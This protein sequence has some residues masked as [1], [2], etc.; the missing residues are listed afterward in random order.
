VPLLLPT[1]LPLL[2]PTPLP[3]LLLLL[4][5]LP[6]LL[7][8]L[9]LLQAHRNLSKTYT[10]SED[11]MLWCNQSAVTNMRIKGSALLGGFL[12]QPALLQKLPVAMPLLKRVEVV[13]AVD[14][15]LQQLRAFVKARVCRHVVVAGCGGRGAGRGEIRE[16]DCVEM[17][18][19]V[20]GAVV[21]EYRM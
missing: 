19:A 20:G 8:L 11:Y 2:L 15:T 5:L 1:P 3:L 7:L 9:L 18:E 13:K 17:Q 10:T 12:V 21:V 14:L 16:T 4:L 6:L